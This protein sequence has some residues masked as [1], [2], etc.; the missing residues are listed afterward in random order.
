VAWGIGLFVRNQAAKRVT[1]AAEPV[2][3]G[4]RA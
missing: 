3:A 1:V 2:A 4:S